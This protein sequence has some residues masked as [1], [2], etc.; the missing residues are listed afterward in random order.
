MSF[1]RFAFFGS[2]NLSVIVLE[3]LSSAGFL[4]SVVVAS[5]DEKKGRGMELTPPPTAI[6]AKQNDIPLLQPESL[7]NNPEL[8]KELARLSYDCFIVASYGKIIP[9]NILGIPLRGTL[10]VHPSLLPRFRGP[11]PIRAQILADEKEV[12]VSIMLI[13]EKVDHGPIVA[14]EVVEIKNWPPGALEL[15]DM[16]ARA[17]G[18]LLA[19]ILPDYLSGKTKPTEQDHAKATLTKKLEKKDGELDLSEDAY[20]NF[21]KIRAYDGWPGTYFFIEKGDPSTSLRAGKKIRVI[22]KEADFIDG[23]LILKKVLPEG[24]R[25]MSYED[26]L[27]G[28]H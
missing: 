15:E 7:K 19:Q 22:I 3:E 6:W 13:D 11:D 20:Q 9:Q 18:K 8:L 27:R 23:K 26:F 5:P 25:E 16:L 14:K 17:G 2:S 12:G 10:N 1:P 4:P 28:I 21:L 24:G